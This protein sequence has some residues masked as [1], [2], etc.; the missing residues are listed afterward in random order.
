MSD[1][2][3]L[4]QEYKGNAEL[5]RAMNDAIV[6]IKKWHFQL[7]GKS[8]IHKDKLLR[9]RQLLSRLVDDI[10]VTIT[11]PERI[12]TPATESSEPEVPSVPLLF[13]NRLI[14]LHRGNLEWYVQDL[15]EL[16]AVLMS[17]GQIEPKSISYMDELCSQLDAETSAAYRRLWRR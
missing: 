2:G 3:V 15:R 4:S 12:P 17:G 9:A 13:V 10:V 8:A 11:D 7:A 1:T 6:L 16:S 5:F 14:E